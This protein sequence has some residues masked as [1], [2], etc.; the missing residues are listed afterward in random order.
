MKN[1]LVIISGRIYKDMLNNHLEVI[2]SI[3][4]NLG[5]QF[6]LKIGLFL[7]ENDR[8]FKYLFEDKI[9]V[10]EFF[11][12]ELFQKKG[13]VKMFQLQEVILKK[14]NKYDY[15]M[16][17]RTDIIIEKIHIVLNNRYNSFKWARGISDNIGI[18]TKDIFYKTWENLDINRLN[19]LGPEIY[20]KKH[21][22]EN[23]I[24]MFNLKCRIKLFKPNTEIRKPGFRIWDTYNG[25]YEYIKI[26]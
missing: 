10:I 11:K 20:L 24:K 19:K 22:K 12:S 6:N 5:K 15:Y 17:M 7:W 3:R 23:K 4:N 13:F 21:T 2:S 18:A 25:T 1:L 9:D 14:Y 8:E 26:N 16:R